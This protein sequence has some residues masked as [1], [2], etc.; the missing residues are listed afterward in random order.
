MLKKLF[1]ENNLLCNLFYFFVIIW[2]V[3]GAFCSLHT[4]FD[5]NLK[6]TIIS[7]V[8]IL[9]LIFVAKF[10]IN[11]LNT[12]KKYVIILSIT[13]IIFLGLF[14]RI[15]ANQVFKTVPV[16]DFNTPHAVYQ[17]K[18]SGIFSKVESTEDQSFYQIYYSTFPAWFPYMKVVSLVYDIFGQNI[19]YI[20]IMN[21]LLYITSAFLIYIIFKD[22]SKKRGLLAMLLFSVFPS[23]VVYSN[24]TTPDHITIFLLLFYIWTWEKILKNRKLE[25]RRQIIWYII[26]NII[27]MC[28]INLFKPLS[29]LGIL[30][31]ICAEIICFFPDVLNKQ[32]RKEYFKKN[33]LY[34]ILFLIISFGALNLENKLLN[35]AVENTINTKVIDSTGLYML[36]GYSINEK[37]DYDSTPANKVYD[38][39]LKKYNN[40]VSKAM[41]ETNEFAKIQFKNNIK[42]LPKIIWQKFR[43]A[44]YT[45][46]DIFSWANN[47]D[48]QS[49]SQGLREKYLKIYIA[50]ANS[51]MTIILIMTAV[52]LLNESRKKEVNNFVVVLALIITGFTCVLVF[53]G[54]Q[55][56]YKTLIL[57]V[58]CLLASG[59]MLFKKEE[60]VK[61]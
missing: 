4:A 42:Y 58:F 20:K 59:C 37:G 9:F 3:A 5:E 46:K 45:E 25:N 40:D 10:F 23:L 56:R 50:V 36:W 60:G 29:I 11:K 27:S 7:V 54:V 2:C 32:T 51:Y 19:L 53:G 61:C 13:F 33:I 28:L 47:S 1:V 41:I 21:W 26:L 34:I 15:L 18:D 48:N 52:S 39:L 17:K 35:E 44:Y 12:E 57:S 16:S 31:F 8:T 24:I 49:Y 38:N 6:G 30:V 55:P 14:F 22:Y 43:I